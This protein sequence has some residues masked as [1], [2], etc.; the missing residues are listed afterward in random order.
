MLLRLLVVVGAS[1][2]AIV[3]VGSIAAAA[4]AVFLVSS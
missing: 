3:L 2:L 4:T 1:V